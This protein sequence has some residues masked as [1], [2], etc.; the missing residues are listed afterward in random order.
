MKHGVNYFHFYTMNRADSVLE[1][2]NATHIGRQRSLAA[3]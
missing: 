3:A 2:L 1:I